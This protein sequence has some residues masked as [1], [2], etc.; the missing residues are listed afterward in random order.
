MEKR[1]YVP[2]DPDYP[3]REAPVDA[4]YIHWL[5]PNINHDSFRRGAATGAKATVGYMPPTPIPKSGTM[6]A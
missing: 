1:G 2:I 5:I 3:K 6:A 4:A